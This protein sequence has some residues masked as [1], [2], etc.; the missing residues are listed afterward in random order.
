MLHSS[1]TPMLSVWGKE[2]GPDG[3]K[4]RKTE[5]VCGTSGAEYKGS[6]SGSSSNLSHGERSMETVAYFGFKMLKYFISD[7]RSP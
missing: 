4:G 3:W 7:D 5:E 1:T 2:G 6:F